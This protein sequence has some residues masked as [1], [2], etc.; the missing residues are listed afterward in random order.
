MLVELKHE[1]RIRRLTY[2]AFEQQV[3]DGQVPPDAEI[4]FDAATGNAFVPLRSL[5]L[6]RELASLD[7]QMELYLESQVWTGDRRLN[8]KFTASIGIRRRPQSSG[9]A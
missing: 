3:R 4:R 6:Y 2:E 1:D 7:Q 8:F 5:E 9:C